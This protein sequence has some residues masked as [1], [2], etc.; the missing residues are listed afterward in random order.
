MFGLAQGAGCSQAAPADRALIVGGDILLRVLDW[1]DRSTVVLGDDGALQWWCLSASST[2][3][4][5][6]LSSEPI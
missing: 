6:G 5:S 4:S 3:V 2:A 1:S